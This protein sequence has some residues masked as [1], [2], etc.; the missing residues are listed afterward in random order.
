MITADTLQASPSDI[1][2]LC[3]DELFLA[4]AAIGHIGVMYVGSSSTRYPQITAADT[5]LTDFLVLAAIE[6]GVD[7]VERILAACD[8]IERR[9]LARVNA[10]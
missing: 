3:L 7:P 4:G 10:T 8:E 1:L 6:L 9:I 5:A 2:R